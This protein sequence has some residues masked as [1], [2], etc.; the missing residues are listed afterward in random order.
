MGLSPSFIQETQYNHRM[1]NRTSRVPYCTAPG[2][3]FRHQ[4]RQQIGRLLRDFLAANQLTPSEVLHSS[5]HQKTLYAANGSLDQAIQ[6]TATEQA[7]ANNTS[8]ATRLEQVGAL[9][10]KIHA[11]TLADDRKVPTAKLDRDT[12]V[13]KLRR[14]MAKLG[15]ADLKYRG[16]RLIVR[17][18][19]PCDG[20][21]EKIDALLVISETLT[22]GPETT[23]GITLVDT[24]IGEVLRNRTALDKILGP[25]RSLGHRLADIAQL[26]RGELEPRAEMAAPN[27]VGRLNK[28]LSDH[29]MRAAR[30]GLAFQIRL[31]LAGRSQI[32]SVE[33]VDELRAIADLYRTLRNGESY[34]GGDAVSQ[35]LDRRI[36]RTLGPGGVSE[37]LPEQPPKSDELE[38]LISVH[39][40]LSPSRAKQMLARLIDQAFSEDDFASQLLHGDE[41]GQRI[42]TVGRLYDVIEKSRLSQQD[43]QRFCDQTRE[44][45]VGFIDDRRFFANLDRAEPDPANKALYLIELCAEGA[46]VPGPLDTAKEAIDSWITSDTFLPNYLNGATD[47]D[48][49]TSM[50]D[51]LHQKLQAI[52]V[53]GPTF[54]PN[55]VAG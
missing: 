8:P 45:Q 48:E 12:C 27:L 16:L 7:T 41:D 10:D 6:A 33:L 15:G 40:Q 1:S 22:R 36:L 5:R 20:W 14:A 24:V 25:A 39:D 50:I 34:V 42:R 11:I 17:Y 37:I 2:H 38:T 29:Q 32:A 13:N 44:I 3:F 23:R 53:E 19:E 4:S 49:R 28:I 46:F 21:R 47:P 18:L 51:A 26:H 55:P 9:V 52:G 35:L 30:A 54:E 31:E 43:K